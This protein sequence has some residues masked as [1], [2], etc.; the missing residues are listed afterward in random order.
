MKLDVYLHG[1]KEDATYLAEENCGDMD[2]KR[3][4]DSI[5]NCTH[6]VM[7]TLDINVL[8]GDSRIIAVDKKP[9]I[10]EALEQST[11]ELAFASFDGSAQ[12]NPG[13]MN[14]GYLIKNT[15]DVIIFRESKNLG[16]GTNNVAEYQALLALLQKSEE[17][18]IEHL[19]IKGDS[20]LIIK[21]VQKEWK[22][23][24]QELIPLRDAC[25]DLI[26]KFKSCELQ[27]VPR[28]QN[29]D[30]DWLSQKR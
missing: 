12:P 20:Q 18:E 23:R 14:I 29:S 11:K 4:Y 30:A 8:T 6:E 25:I 26:N 2:S 7:V 24:K 3:L 9:I 16:F 22:C 27:W 5:L 13:N 19:A 10:D 1:S 28:N 21:Q 17:L 15:D